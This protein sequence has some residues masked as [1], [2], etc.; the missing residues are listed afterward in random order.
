MATDF[1]TTDQKCLLVPFGTLDNQHFSFLFSRN[2]TSDS[3]PFPFVFNC[4]LTNS[5]LVFQSIGFGLKIITHSKTIEALERIAN[6]NFCIEFQLN[7][8]LKRRSVQVTSIHQTKYFSFS[9]SFING[10]TIQWMCKS[11]RAKDFLTLSPIKLFLLV[12][13]ISTRK[14]ICMSSNIRPE[15]GR[16]KD[17]N[18]L[19][20]NISSCVC[21]SLILLLSQ[22]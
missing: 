21:V 20:R 10:N 11:S 12:S 13:G 5:Q 1:S 17:R 19:T 16:E 14:Q 7:C 3:F 2:S 15:W 22:T 4:W 8:V 6:Q 18:K 9:L